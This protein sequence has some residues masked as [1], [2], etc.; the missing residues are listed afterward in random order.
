MNLNEQLESSQK[1]LE[2][3]L[4]HHRQTEI[5][6]HEMNGQVKLLQWMID[7]EKAEAEADD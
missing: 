5:A 4:E 1:S 6:I 3:A 7:E 2:A